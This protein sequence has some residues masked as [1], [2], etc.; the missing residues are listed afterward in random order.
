MEQLRQQIMLAQTGNGDVARAISQARFRPR[1]AAF[2][3]LL[4]FVSKAK[5]PDKVTFSC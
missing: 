3:S 1:Q 2:T 4:Q 5:Q